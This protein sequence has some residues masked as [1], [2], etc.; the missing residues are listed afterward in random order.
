MQRTL[1]ITN[2]EVGTG[3]F[4]Y[5]EASLNPA[6]SKKV[7]KKKNVKFSCTHFTV[8][9]DLNFSIRFT[10]QRRIQNLIKL[11]RQRFLGKELRAESR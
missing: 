10:L 6:L 3:F 8:A 7:L 4:R 2:Y 1:I 11:L 5:S 9:I